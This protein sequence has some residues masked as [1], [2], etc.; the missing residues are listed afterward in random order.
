MSTWIYAS[1]RYRKDAHIT[2]FIELHCSYDVA[3]ILLVAGKAFSNIFLW[4]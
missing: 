2:A 3:Q 4:E 1:F